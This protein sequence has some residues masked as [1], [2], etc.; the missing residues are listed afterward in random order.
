RWKAGR[1]R[2]TISPR[3]P[4]RTAK[5]VCAEALLRWNHPQLG[6]IPP[7]RFIPVAEASGLIIPIGA[8]VI[9]EV[10]RQLRIWRTEGRSAISV[11]VNLSAVQFRRNDVAETVE[12]ALRSNDVHPSRLEMEIR[13]SVLLHEAADVQNNLR[14]LKALGVRLA[15]D[16]FGVGYSSFAY[17]KRFEVDKLKIDRTFVRDAPKDIEDAAIVRAIA[18]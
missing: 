4:S 3:G 7:S 18:Q 9:A 12:S 10:C 13:E 5:I 6:E 15:I 8:W 2:C 14:A 11:A 1:W 17:L 16:D